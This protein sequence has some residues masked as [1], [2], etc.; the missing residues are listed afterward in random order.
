MNWRD[1][2]EEFPSDDI[3]LCFEKGTIYIC[4][5]METKW[6]NHYSSTDWKHGEYGGGED[7][8]YWMPIPKP[9]TLE[10]CPTASSI[11][12]CTQ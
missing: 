7:W 6:G 8:T 4:E 12:E 11:P 1:R 10:E 5:L 2:E 9:P 3:I